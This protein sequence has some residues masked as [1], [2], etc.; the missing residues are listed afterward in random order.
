[1]NS[2]IKK[3][4]LLFWQPQKD[5]LKIFDHSL[6]GEIGLII[7]NYS[8]WV[9]FFVVSYLLIR[10]DINFFGRLF[11]IT[12]IA[13]LIEKYLKKQKI[14]IRPMFK[15]RSV[16]PIGLVN[17]W[18]YSGS[19][20][21]GH[22]IKMIY[23]LLFIISTHIISIPLFLVITIPLLTFRVLAGFHYPIDIIG[24][25]VIGFILWFFS[26]DLTFPIF[27]NNFIQSIFNFI[28]FIK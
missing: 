28:F 2:L 16:A 7:C 18:Y 15:H 19:F 8:I 27:L 13:E 23:F 9:F 20:P 14:W 10:Y 4:G 11:L 17:S 5:Y 1:M 12:L 3:P 24:G 25:I 26:K 22:T 21:S 6:L